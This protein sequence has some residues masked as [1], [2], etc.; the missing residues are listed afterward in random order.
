MAFKSLDT[1]KSL[2]DSA[3]LDHVLIHPELSTVSLR[4]IIFVKKGLCLTF[5]LPTASKIK[6]RPPPTGAS[7]WRS[8]SIALKHYVL[9]AWSHVDQIYEE[10]CTIVWLTVLMR[11]CEWNMSL[12]SSSDDPLRMLY[13]CATIAL[14]N[15]TIPYP[16][17]GQATNIN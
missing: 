3:Q 15:V 12:A 2:I 11:T 8:L 14:I 17:D 1:N 13:A 16:I 5:D 9:H 10:L 7:N 6:N 4:I